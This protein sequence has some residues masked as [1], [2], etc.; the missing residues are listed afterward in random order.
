MQHNMYF[1]SKLM[2]F[3]IKRPLMKGTF[4][5]SGD[6]R[7]R[8][9]ILRPPLLTYHDGTFEVRVYTACVLKFFFICV[10]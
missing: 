6:F 2:D 10:V 9:F 1:N 5:S 8:W 7:G 4:T 3:M